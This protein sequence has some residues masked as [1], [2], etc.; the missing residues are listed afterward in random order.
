LITALLVKEIEGTGRL[1]LGRFYGRRAR[2]LLPALTLVLCATCLAGFYVFTP[3]EQTRLL[4]SAFA[5]VGYVSNIYFARLSTDYFG[6]L[7]DTNPFLHTW[8]LS[9]EEQFYLIWPLLVLF[10]LKGGRRRLFVTMGVIFISTLALSIWLT[11]IRQPWAFFNSP[12]RAWEFAA[13]GICALLARQTRFTE[14]LRWA[15]LAATI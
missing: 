2:R 4:K 9:V 13:G 1:R 11:R 6:Q 8:T 14:L 12:P 5:T 10:A 3:I 7:G 15:G